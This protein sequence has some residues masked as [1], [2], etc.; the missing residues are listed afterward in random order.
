MH[1]PDTDRRVGI[2]LNTHNAEIARKRGLEIY[3]GFVQTYETEQLFDVVSCYAI[4]EH[5]GDPRP[6]LRK[7][8]A[9]V[10]PGGMLV[11]LVPS[12]DTG[13]RRLADWGGIYWHMFAPPSHLTY[14][15]R[16]Y[17]D[18]FLTQNGL[19]RVRRTYSS[20]GISSNYL[21]F[22]ATF[23]LLRS[24][25]YESLR[26]YFSSALQ[27][28]TAGRESRLVKMARLGFTMILNL[29]D[30]HTPLRLAPFFDHMYS[31]YVRRPFDR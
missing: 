3:T 4:L 13:I 28:Q 21:P 31:Y 20:G 22:T 11:I 29:L 23:R 15:S 30:R 16:P 8:A 9:L 10:K 17:L 1:W 24:G 27:D 26:L 2:E 6:I 25:S 7:L 19:T 14:Y 12:Y 18:G 5:V